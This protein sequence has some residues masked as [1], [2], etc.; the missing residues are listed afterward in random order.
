MDSISNNSTSCAQDSPQFGNIPAE[1]REQPHWVFWVAEPN[2]DPTKKPSKIP[3]NATTGRWAQINNPETF[4]TYERVVKAIGAVERGKASGINYAFGYD[5]FVGI[6][7]DGVLDPT[8]RLPTCELAAGIIRRFIEAGAY[9]EVSPSGTGVRIVCRG[10]MPR[11]GKGLGEFKHFEVYGRGPGG[12]HFLSITGHAIQTVEAIPVC[13]TELDWLYK[14]YFKRQ[15][16]VTQ[17]AVSVSWMESPPLDDDEIIEK[18][19]RSKRSAEFALLFDNGSTDNPSDDDLKLCSMAA[20]YTQDADQIDRIFRQSKLYRDKWERTDYREPTIR[21]ALEELRGTWQ[22]RGESDGERYGI[23]ESE[24]A[25]RFLD[26]IA[27]IV[28]KVLRLTRQPQVFRYFDGIWAL[29]NHGFELKK[30]VRQIAKAII[31]EMP[32][33][34]DEARRDKLYNLAKKLESKRGLDDIS[35]LVMLGLPEFL[36]DQSNTRD[37]FFCA[38]NGTIDLRWG[39]LY[40]H[41]ESNQFTLRSS[42]TYDVEAT[43]PLWIKFVDEFCCADVEMVRFVQAWC[44]YCI[45]G[46]V[47]EQKMAIFYGP[48]ANGN[49]VLLETVKHVM[50]DFAAVIPSNSLLQRQSEAS[51]D[52]A[53]LAGKRFVVASES[54]EGK[55]LAEGRVK[56]LTGGDEIVCRKLFEEFQTFTPRFKLNLMTNHKPRVSGSDFGIWRRLLLIPCDAR[57]D[58]PDKHLITKLK[59]EASGILNWLIEGYQIWLAEGLTIPSRISAATDAYR[60][61][62]DAVGRFI[63]EKCNPFS[64]ELRSSVVYKSYS[65]WCVLEGMKPL[66]QPRF[67][68]KMSE[69]GF[70]SRKERTGMFYPAALN[71]AR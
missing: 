60:A 5:D 26:S 22:P 37:G 15:E 7:L 50:G 34:V 30:S 57:V 18:L 58:N 23:S 32:D 54:D 8:S 36:P 46:D 70:P 66:S 40:L 31:A 59:A 64:G 47:S 45:S 29:D 39:N 28:F 49:S 20:F 67:S 56:A 13:Q 61:E 9:A 1:M 16:T 68:Q 33:E 6:D 14:A 10:T 24:A 44:G 55:P 4:A 3:H 43:C 62:C 19:R 11:F 17:E 65:E 71:Y 69:K 52:I 2:L 53:M 12:L 42:V 63:N 38:A 51:N 48:G 35:S 27:A 21:K 41:S 25:R